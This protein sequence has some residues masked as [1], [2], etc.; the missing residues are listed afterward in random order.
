VGGCGVGDGG[1]V[2]CWFRWDGV[3]VDA[4]EFVVLVESEDVGEEAILLGGVPAPRIRDVLD[5]DC[6]PMLDID[7]RLMILFSFTVKLVSEIMRASCGSLCD[8]PKVHP[9]DVIASGGMFLNAFH[10]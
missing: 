9:I 10:V 3:R 8:F 5:F 7:R 2:G 4:G 1:V 6:L